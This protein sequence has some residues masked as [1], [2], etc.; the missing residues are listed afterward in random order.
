MNTQQSTAKKSIPFKFQCTLRNVPGQTYQR[1]TCFLGFA[2]SSYNRDKVTFSTDLANFLCFFDLPAI[3]TYQKKEV[4]V[5][6][7]RETLMEK[8][9][10]III[11]ALDQTEP[12]IC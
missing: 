11:A 9:L 1:K 2:R 5:V 12:E 7:K 3:D 4:M 8:L 6:E 10:A